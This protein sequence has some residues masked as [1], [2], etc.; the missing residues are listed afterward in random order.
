MATSGACRTFST[1]AWFTTATRCIS[2]GA[3]MGSRWHP[4][5]EIGHLHNLF[6]TVYD[7][8]RVTGLIQHRMGARRFFAFMP[9][10]V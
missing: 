4:L 9:A 7:K 6:F 10:P 8:G 5:E 2:T 1:I 3:V